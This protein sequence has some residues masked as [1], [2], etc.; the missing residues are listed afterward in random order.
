MPKVAQIGTVEVVEAWRMPR[1]TSSSAKVLVD[2]IAAARSTV[3]HSM[4]LHASSA[5][6]PWNEALST[7]A[8]AFI[9][10]LLYCKLRCR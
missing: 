7:G 1:D 10:P 9:D 3:V 2:F 4:A 6:W 5:S 8:I